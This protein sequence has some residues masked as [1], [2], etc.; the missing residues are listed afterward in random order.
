M[1]SFLAKRSITLKI[2]DLNFRWAIVTSRNNFLISFTPK[3]NPKRKKWM[4]NLSNSFILHNESCT[5]CAL[6]LCKF[7]AK[8]QLE[9]GLHEAIC[10]TDSFVFKLGHCVNF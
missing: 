2:S 6:I 4:P 7:E 5:N 1:R 9:P 10:L 8:N 3:P